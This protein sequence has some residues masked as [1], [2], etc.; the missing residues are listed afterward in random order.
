MSKMTDEE[1]VNNCN[2]IN[3]RGITHEPF[4]LKLLSIIEP[5]E[6]DELY[7]I[8]FWVPHS[9]AFK[10][11]EEVLFVEKVLPLYFN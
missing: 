1:A 2:Y 9:R 10:I 8:I 11:H 5:S 4:P 7:K 3:I 6:E